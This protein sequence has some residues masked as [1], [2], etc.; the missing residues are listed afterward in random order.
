MTK[1]ITKKKTIL[2]LEYKF[3]WMHCN[4]KKMFFLIIETECS[5]FYCGNDLL[6][7]PSSRLFHCAHQWR[8]INGDVNHKKNISHAMFPFPQSHTYTYIL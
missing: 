7:G 8:T 1:F 4:E 5:F 3:L 2:A 6:M